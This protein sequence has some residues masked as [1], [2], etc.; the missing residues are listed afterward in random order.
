MA[1]QKV[2]NLT[3]ICIAS[4]YE[5][6][7]LVNGQFVSLIAL[8]TVLLKDA[9]A[10]LSPLADHECLEGRSPHHLLFLSSWHDAYTGCTIRVC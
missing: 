10:Y 6:V 2:L 5:G 1:L 9:F 7:S 4:R 8:L 3:S